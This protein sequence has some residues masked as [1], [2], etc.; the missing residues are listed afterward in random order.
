MA[1]RYYNLEKETKDAL[2]ESERIGIITTD[3][4]ETL[5]DYVIKRKA[6]GY[7]ADHI[8]NNLVNINGLKLWLDFGDQNSYSGGNVAKDLSLNAYNFDVLNLPKFTHSGKSSYISLNGSNQ[9]L[10]KLSFPF[11]YTSNSFTA[12]FWI[13][14]PATKGVHSIFLSGSGPFNTNGFGS[15]IRFRTYT[16]EATRNDAI[17]FGTR[18][19]L[20]NS[21][22][23]NVWKYFSFSFDLPT[24]TGRLY[25]NNQLSTTQSYAG[26]T[27]F[28]SSYEMKIG[29]GT[30]GFFAGDIAQFLVYDRALGLSDIIT[31]FNLTR[32]RFGL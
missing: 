24:L 17:S 14:L 21:F 31:N 6:L 23:L 12:S 16:M 26:E 22:A 32:G 2:K 1:K 10:R 30:D 15:E 18:T 19:I 9:Y 11:S 29:S 13:R 4:I 3:S 28:N 8:K 27:S 7:G 20:N 25:A 5:N